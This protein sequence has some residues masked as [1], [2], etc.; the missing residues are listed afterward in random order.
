MMRLIL[1]DEEADALER[2]LD[3]ILTSPHLAEQVFR[4]G[5]E[6]RAIRRVSMKIDWSRPAKQGAA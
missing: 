2:V 6:R 5:D 4:G 1:Q 3:L